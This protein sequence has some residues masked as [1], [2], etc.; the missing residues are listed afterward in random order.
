MYVSTYNNALMRRGSYGLGPVGQSQMWPMC[1]N[2]MV[3]DILRQMYHS[4]L[5]FIETKE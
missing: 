4:M 3:V 2:R 5:G 1:P